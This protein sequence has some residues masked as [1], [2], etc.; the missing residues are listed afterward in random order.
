MP[1]IVEPK[2]PA[3]SLQ[4]LVDI[5]DHA[6]MRIEHTVVTNEGVTGADVDETYEPPLTDAEAMYLLCLDQA[7]FAETEEWAAAPLDN[8][9]L[10]ALQALA[11]RASTDSLRSGWGTLDFPYVRDEQGLVTDVEAITAE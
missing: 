1:S 9:N 3:T 8:D 10:L 4:N 6:L 2:S 7:D 11:L 5:A